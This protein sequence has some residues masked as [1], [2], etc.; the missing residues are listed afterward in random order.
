[1]VYGV[2]KILGASISELHRD[3]TANDFDKMQQKA[4]N[5]LNARLCRY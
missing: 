1:M 2:N 5:F 4:R 3:N